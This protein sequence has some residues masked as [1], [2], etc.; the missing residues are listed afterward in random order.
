MTL[1]CLLAFVCT[2]CVTALASA[3][4][5]KFVD[6]PPD[7]LNDAVELLAK[8]YEVDVIY[9]SDLIRGRE[10]PGLNGAFEAE[11]AFKKLL[12]GTPLVL[13]K[14]G[15]ALLITQPASAFPQATARNPA[16]GLPEVLVEAQRGAA[17]A[18]VQPTQK[19]EP[20]FGWARHNAEKQ[21]V[22]ANAQALQS[23]CQR[24]AKV[25]DK[26]IQVYCTVDASPHRPRSVRTA[27]VPEAS[28]GDT[29]CRRLTRP[30]SNRIQSFC[31]DRAL[32]EE[33]DIWAVTAEVTC[34]WAG[35]SQ[36]LCLTVAQWDSF[37]R[38][39]RVSGAAS[40][41]PP[42]PAPTNGTAGQYLYQATDPDRVMVRP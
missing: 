4:T 33:F 20:I 21:A 8:W 11:D 37:D 25:G 26:K 15:D 9:P 17:E 27:R 19:R 31:V 12:E 3:G 14:E 22:R 38:A 6:V 39:R 7:D 32:W 13:S 40:N 35:T 29:S 28:S 23:T 42:A 24:L 5:P 10:T 34:R 1:R 16:E 18:G 41:W 2:S 30:G 36:E